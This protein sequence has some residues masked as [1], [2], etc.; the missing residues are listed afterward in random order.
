MRTLWEFICAIRGKID[1][2]IVWL[3]GCCTCGCDAYRWCRDKEI[4]CVV[5]FNSIIA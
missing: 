2:G 4:T 1:I 3:P 5:D